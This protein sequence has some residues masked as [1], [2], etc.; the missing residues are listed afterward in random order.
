[1]KQLLLG[2]FAV[3]GGAALCGLPHAF[4]QAPV[5]DQS[6][7]PGCLYLPATEYAIGTEPPEVIRETAYKDIGGMLRKVRMAIRIPK[8]APTLLPVVIWSHGG[9]YG[10]KEPEGVMVEWSRATA[11]AGYLTVTIAHQPREDFAGRYRLC[12]APPLSMDNATCDL[13]KYLHWDRPHDITAVLNELERMNTTGEFRGRIDLRRI[14]LGGHSAGA[15]GALSVAGALRNFTGTV[16]DMRDPRPMAFLAF[17]PQG[18]G[19]EGFFD[20]DF[21]QRQHSWMNIERP[22]LIGTGDG[23]STCDR[24]A[25]PGSCFGDS[26]YIRRITFERMQAGNKYQLYL[27]D[28]DTFHTL[29]ELNTGEC[30]EKG[31]EQAK[32]DEIA[33]WLISTALAFLDGHLRRDPLALEWLNS[34]HIVAASRGVAQWRVK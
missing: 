26:P 13:F 4:G 23:D 14:A 5:C 22:V 10:K 24:L 17:S 27:A 2:L 28:A 12:A 31:V 33:R 9:A 15:G 34:N 18:P 19:S 21:K 29:F 7:A 30:S 3:I 32:C 20:T 1:M 16:L 25:E 11:K 8:N 6:L